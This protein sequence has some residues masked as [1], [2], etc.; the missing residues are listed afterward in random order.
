MNVS[1][2]NINNLTKE[3]TNG[4][5]LRVLSI[6]KKDYS[7]KKE[8]LYHILCKKISEINEDDTRRNLFSTRF[9]ELKKKEYKNNI[10]EGLFELI[11]FF[12]NK[13]EYEIC[14]MLKK[15]KDNLLMD[16]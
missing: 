6:L 10:I 9:K 11:S 12:E 8:D 13:E 16:L 1:T 15:V 3:E 2:I 14:A 4:F 7:E 5:V